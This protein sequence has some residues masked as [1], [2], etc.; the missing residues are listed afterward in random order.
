LTDR[1]EVVEDFGVHRR[2]YLVELQI[3]PT[4]PLVGKTVENAGLR[5]LPGLFLIE[6]D[7]NGDVLTPV[8][9]H[10]TI[11]IDDRLVFT[12]VVNTIVDLEKI[13]GLV[14]TA[15]LTYD[16]DPISRQQR[17]LTEVV[18]SRSSPLIGRTLRDANFRRMYNAAVVAVHRSG[19]RVT[20]KLGNIR[21]EPG[22]TL[23]LQTRSDFVAQYRNHRDFYLVSGVEGSEPLRYHK[24]PL[25]TAL[26]AVLI[27]WL[28]AANFI[29]LDGPL[30]SLAS[31]AVASVTI[32]GL[33]VAT[34]C[35][36]ISEARNSIDLQTLVTIAA[37]IGLGA[38][39]HQSGAAS[40]IAQTFVDL[41]GNNPY[42]LLVVVYLLSLGCTEAISNAAVAAMMLPL[43]AS[44]AWESGSDPRPF[45]MA[46][47]MAASLAF[48]TPIGYQT[49]LMV[50]GPAGYRPSDYFRMGWPITLAV[51]ITS[52]ILIPWIW[53]LSG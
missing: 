42:L 35:L 51:S 48:L 47:T 44:V 53:P 46:V 29:D 50:M 45:V 28:I 39:L 40:A 37:S 43:A 4:C 12:G 13:P 7:R 21:L 14:P 2:E 19:Q 24:L 49:N 11:Q 20:T 1:K 27:A 23:L 5:K 8:A 36:R 16:S 52:L 30:A 38:A 9:P 10:Q 3:T 22:D 41:V 18:L 15:D 31:V 17:R 6:I 32:A 26:T 34:R 33:M 25:A